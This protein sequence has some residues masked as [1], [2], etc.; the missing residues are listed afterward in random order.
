M[1]ATKIGIWMDHQH[2]Y[3]T[4]FTDPMNTATVEAATVHKS[5]S[6]HVKHHAEQ[7]AT[8]DF[9]K[10]LSGVVRDYERVLLF[11]PNRHKEEFYNRLRDDHHFAGIR[12]ELKPAGK[13]TIHEQ[14]EFV[15][16][17]FIKYN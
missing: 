12:F 1:K 11:G 6:E 10:T 3:L 8:N 15:K 16:Q 9:Y 4:P 14:Q 2:A 5:G 7:N 17:Y 13:M